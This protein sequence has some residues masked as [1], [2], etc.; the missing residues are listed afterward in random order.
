MRLQRSDAVLALALAVLE[1]ERA[2]LAG[3]GVAG[4]LRLSGGSS[5]PG[6]LTRGDVD[7]HLRVPPPAFAAT[8]ERL[9]AVHRPVH[10]GIWQ[11][12][13]LA[14]FD[15]VDAPAPTGLAV[16]PVG[17]EHDD[18]FV[19]CWE[20]LAADPSARAA[21]SETK[22]RT[23]PLGAEE[24]ERAKSAFFDALLAD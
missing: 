7:L 22:R 21:Y 16:T 23:A 12:G 1:H 14:T 4:E 19:R 18:R 6:L 9:R 10:P 20:R 2:R 15:V 3:L 24:Y 5:L 11:A 17:S 13:S 8:V